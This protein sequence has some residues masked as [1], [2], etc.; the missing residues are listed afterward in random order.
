M[1]KN[2]ENNKHLRST[3][4]HQLSYKYLYRKTDT[5]PLF[6][7]QQSA[8]NYRIFKPTCS[9]HELKICTWSEKSWA[10]LQS[11]SLILLN[12]IQGLH[13]FASSKEELP[14][15]IP[16]G[17]HVNALKAPNSTDIESKC[18]CTA[19]VLPSLISWVY[20]SFT[21]RF[22]RA[23]QKVSIGKTASFWYLHELLMH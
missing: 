15:T 21:S 8:Q 12:W 2:A 4:S 18:D 10:Q 9:T 20:A 7:A 14:W 6:T 5:K 19:P 16:N 1:S 13:I 22:F 17:G 23:D 11:D 3:S